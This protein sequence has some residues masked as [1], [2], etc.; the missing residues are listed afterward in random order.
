M[1][2]SVDVRPGGRTA[3]VLLL[4]SWCVAGT[5]PGSGNATADP[6]KCKTRFL[7]GSKGTISSPGYPDSYSNHTSCDWYIFGK[8]GQV[9]TISFDQV[10]IEED[11]SCGNPPCCNYNWL[12]IGSKFNA[13]GRRYCG[14]KGTTPPPFFSVGSRVWIKFHVSNVARGGRGFRLSYIISSK[15][16][17]SCGE[18]EFHCS[19]S[20]CILSRWRCNRFNECRDGSDERFCPDKCPDDFLRCRSGAGCYSAEGHCDGKADCPDLSDELDCAFCGRNRVRCGPGSLRCYH[21]SAQRCDRVTDCENGEDEKGCFGCGDKMAC[22]S[23]RGCYSGVQRCN[24]VAEC[25]DDSDEINC[26]PERCKSDGGGFLCANGRCIREI[27]KCDRTDDCGDGSDE[28]N[29][30]PLRPPPGGGRPPGFLS[31]YADIPVRGPPPAAFLPALVTLGGSVGSRGL[32]PPAE[33]SR[34]PFLSGARGSCLVRGLLVPFLCRSEEQRGVGSGDGFSG[35]RPAAGGGRGL[36]LSP[37][38]PQ[39]GGTSRPRPGD[40]DVALPAGGGPSRTATFLRLFGGLVRPP[41]SRPPG[42]ASASFGKKGRV[43]AAPAPSRLSARPPGQGRGRGFGSGRSPRPPGGGQGLSPPPGP[44]GG[45]G[46]RGR[47]GR[48]G[49]RVG[50][51]TA[52]DGREVLRLFIEEKPFYICIYF[53]KAEFI[54]IFLFPKDLSNGSVL[55]PTAS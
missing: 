24:G 20:G 7:Y 13:K 54:F 28:R 8:P 47:N 12:K 39:T 50:R 41:P 19:D 31:K 25:G 35:V 1:H 43:G 14:Q 10:D 40:P 42:S 23:G 5:A 55:S 45:G 16:A 37:L 26:G 29:C 4:L 9:V 22:S 53:N 3:R 49:L 18:D 27:W 38:F 51:R 17:E 36:H 48:L 21:P 44:D 34:R 11:R 52:S 15:R 6:E 33:E 2:I 32:L 30:K 46:G